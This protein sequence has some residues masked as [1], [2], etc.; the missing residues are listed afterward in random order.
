M[1]TGIIEEVGAV[2]RRSGAELAIMAETVMGDLKLGDSV[3]VDGVCLTVA[4]LNPDNF[5]VQISPETYARTTLGRLKAGHAVNLERAL[6]AGQRFGGHFVLGHVDGVG[7]VENIRD[8]GEFALWRFKAP[9][10]VARYLAPK[11]SI[12]VDGI[13]LTVVEPRGDLF[14]VALIPT[15][16]AKT[17]IGQKRVGDPVNMEA[18]ILGK[19]ILHYLRGTAKEGVSLESL[20]QH[21]FI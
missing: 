15:T 19:H 17:T 14:S 2:S 13:S 7:R 6:A 4:A 18:D 20:A 9:Q 11:G 16:L 10:E 1:F 12:A 3:A 5:I 21:G 8:Q